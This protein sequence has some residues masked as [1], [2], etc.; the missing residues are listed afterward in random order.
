MPEGDT[1]YLAGQRLHAALAGQVLRRTD[2]R[3]PR[4][5]TTDLSG[6][7]VDAVVS[8]GKHLLLRVSGGL[9]L[10]THFRMDGTWHLY[11]AGKRWH[12]PAWQA[13][14]V[15]TTDPWLAVGF[16]LPVVEVLPTT[17]EADVVGHLGPDPLADDWDAG[18]ALRRLAAEPARVI[19][20][21]LLDQR[22]IAGPGNVY[23]CEI[24]FLRGLYPWTPVGEVKDLP[25]L[26]DLV[27]RLFEVN[28]DGASH[29]TT[30][31]TRPGRQ[32]W[33]YGRGGQPCRRCGTPI[34]RR[35]APPG[36]EDER[37]TYWCPHCQPA[38]G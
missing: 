5:A 19:G 2:F 38:R 9:T 24:C 17:R 7:T 11:Q 1:V 30:G 20:D 6:R 26:V 31:D 35:D 16:R 27:K 23:R 8:R 32:Q 28:R 29:I 25:R 4:L 33:V 22:V 37:I 34:Q 14:V 3:V 18:E 12:A 36:L 13:R 15:L 21:A 10:H